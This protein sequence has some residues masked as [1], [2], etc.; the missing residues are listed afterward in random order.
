MCLPSMPIPDLA[1]VQSQQRLRSQSQKLFFEEP[2]GVGHKHHLLA[3]VKEHIKTH[4]S[5]EEVEKM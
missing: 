3:A 1:L 4:C 2:P 5:S